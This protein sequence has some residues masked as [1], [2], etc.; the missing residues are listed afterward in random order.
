MSSPTATARGLQ[1]ADVRLASKLHARSG[2]H[3]RLGHRRR[4]MSFTAATHAAR[5]TRYG[6]MKAVGLH[7]VL[8]TRKQG[9]RTRGKELVVR[10]RWIQGVLLERKQGTTRPGQVQ[11]R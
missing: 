8:P 2:T 3:P 7:V 6:A 1:E 11:I 4:I 5:S 9:V 10:P